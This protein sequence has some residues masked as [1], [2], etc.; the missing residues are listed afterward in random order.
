M[1][2]LNFLCEQ[3]IFLS[4][5]S[6]LQIFR[7]FQ[8]LFFQEKVNHYEVHAVF[9]DIEHQLQ[10]NILHLFLYYRFL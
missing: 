3:H 9:L 5:A 4:H 8:L 7:F 2:V 1:L 10:E 6:W